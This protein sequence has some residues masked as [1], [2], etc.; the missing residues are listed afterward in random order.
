MAASGL[1][2]NNRS[3]FSNATVTA[4]GIHDV[5]IIVA[6]GPFFFNGGLGCSA[7]DLSRNSRE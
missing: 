4:A 2:A 7:G 6:L 1:S 5:C 3:P